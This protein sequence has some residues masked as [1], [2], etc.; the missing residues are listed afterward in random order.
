MIGYS[1]SLLIGLACQIYR[2]V[3][4]YFAWTFWRHKTYWEYGSAALQE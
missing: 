4:W 2:T 1:G 3:V